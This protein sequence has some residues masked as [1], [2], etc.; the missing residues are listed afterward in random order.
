MLVSRRNFLRTIGIGAATGAAV[1]LPFAGI[2]RAARFEP[3]RTGKS[4]G[5]ILLN[6]NENVYG[7]SAKTAAAIRS[8][9]DTTNRYPF[10]EYDRLTERIAGFH[11]VKPEQVLLGCGSTEILRVAAMAFLG[12]G[13][14]LVQAT[15]TFEAIEQY[16][17]S[18]GAEV[19]SVPLNNEFAH[20]LDS[21]L[22]QANASTTLVYVCN[23]NNPT[24]SI[25]PRKD[26]ETF[27]GKLP[28]TTYVVIDEAYHHYAGQSAMYA[29]F[30]EHPINNDGRVI[31]CRTFSKVYGLA[32]LRLGYAIASPAIVQ[33]METFLTQDDIN[34]MV[35]RAAIAAL[36][37]TDSVKDFVR[38]NTDDRQ[39]FFNQAMARML[40]PIDSHANFVMM[41]THHP[42]QETIEHFRQ[43]NILIGRRFPAMDTYIRVSLGT[44]DQMRAFWRTWDKLPY[45]KAPMHH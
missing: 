39:E 22:A 3:S 27:I 4:G 10:M 30:I 12:K 23:P 44:T 16:A 2:A 19:V 6:S 29:S 28:A 13:K 15:P 45:A 42:A 11:G 5:P 40:K 1:Q 9:L 18:T 35:A 33:R 32:G 31:V 36:D 8:A 14:Q 24:A 41:N 21:M 26:L 37:D 43:N 20:D 17:R 38:R 7:P 34:G 25:T